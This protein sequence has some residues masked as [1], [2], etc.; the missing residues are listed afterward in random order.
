MKTSFLFRAIAILIIAISIVSCKDKQ[1]HFSVQGTI[2]D[3]DSTY[4]Y[5]IKR[6]LTQTDIIDSVKLDEKG[7]FSFEQPSPEYPEFYS[8]RLRSQAINFAID[9]TEDITV[10]ASAPT[11]ATEYS[12]SGAESAV[13]IREVTLNQY[14]LSNTLYILRTELNNKQITENTYL[15][16]LTEAI[17]K[18]KDTAEN[19]IKSDYISMAA[20]YTLFQKVNDYLIFDPYEKKDRRLF[21]T[22]ATIWKQQREGEPRTEHLEKFTLQVISEAR[23]IE[24]QNQILDS[25]G[26]K[27]T[28]IEANDFY[29]IT[30]PDLKN[31]TLN[32]YDLKGKAVLLD[33]TAYQAEYSPAHNIAINKAYE[34]YKNQLEIY[35]VSF[36]ND[37]H[38]WRNTAVNL[39]WKCVRDAKSLQSNLLYKFNIEALPTTFILNKN[40]EIVKRLSPSDNIVDEVK[41]IL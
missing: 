11:F 35:Q 33:F 12:I 16:K 26:N 39:P 13:K 34:K 29:N 4:L 28:T 14:E 27:A 2:S 21:Q 7:E 5:L 1:P 19:I 41:K 40:G 24:K 20:Y 3:A 6:S 15:A 37:E 10:K 36:D 31:T 17:D 8:L 22:V 30:L 38:A 25:L 32:L 23:S 18:Y 9:S